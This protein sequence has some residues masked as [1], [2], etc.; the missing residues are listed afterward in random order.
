MTLEKES[1]FLLFGRWLKET[2]RTGRGCANLWIYLVVGM[3]LCGGAG[4]WL[5]LLKSHLKLPQSDLLMTFC[6]FAPAIAGASCMDFIFG[7]NER[8]YLRGF[9]ILF[10]AI[11]LVFT[12]VA[13]FCTNYWF[14]SFATIVSLSLWWLANAE[15]PKL[16]DTAHSSAP[17]GGDANG[18]VTGTKGTIK[19]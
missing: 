5:L 7:E 16:S 12:L 6:S 15:N 14:A 2:W 19:V 1:G 17:I 3:V 11:V 18:E 9:S 8:K 4:F 10:G 13:F